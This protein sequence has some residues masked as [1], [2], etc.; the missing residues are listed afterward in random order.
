[1]YFGCRNYMFFQ[2]QEGF[3]EEIANVRH[4]RNSGKNVWLVR[5]CCGFSPTSVTSAVC[6]LKSSFSCARHL[7]FFFFFTHKMGSLNIMI[8]EASLLALTVHFLLITAWLQCM[9]RLW[10]SREGWKTSRSRNSIEKAKGKFKEWEINQS[11]LV[12]F[13]KLCYLT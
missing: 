7:L 4:F 3:L 2:V 12:L 1:M 9:A 5:R 6:E 10:F 13:H 8:R 11:E